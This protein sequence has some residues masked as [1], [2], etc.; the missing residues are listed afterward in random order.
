MNHNEVPKLVEQSSTILR[1]K[2]NH[3]GLF[4]PRGRHCRQNMTASVVDAACRPF[5]NASKEDMEGACD[6]LAERVEF[7]EDI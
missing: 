3:F 1:S 4:H 7:Q 6:D 5:S 2:V